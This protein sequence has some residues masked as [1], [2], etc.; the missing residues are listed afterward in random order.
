MKEPGHI[1]PSCIEVLCAFLP[2]KIL[3][4]V[5]FSLVI[6]LLVPT[7]SHLYA[8]SFGCFSIVQDTGRL[9]SLKVALDTLPAKLNSADAVYDTLR[10]KVT[11]PLNKV[12]SIQG[13]LNRSG[14]FINDGRGELPGKLD[15]LRKRSRERL[16]A[17][18][19]RQ[20]ERLQ[21]GVLDDRP[22][23]KAKIE[24]RLTKTKARRLDR[25]RNKLPGDRLGLEELDVPWDQTQLNDP[26]EDIDSTPA[27]DDLGLPAGDVDGALEKVNS[28]QELSKNDDGQIDRVMDQ[29]AKKWL[30]ADQLPPAQQ[31]PFQAQKSQLSGYQGY[32]PHQLQDK[33][34]VKERLKE[35]LTA[36]GK[37]LDFFQDQLQA[38][39]DKVAKH[40]RKYEELSNSHDLET[41]KPMQDKPLRE[42]LIWGGTFQVRPGSPTHIDLSPQVTYRVSPR[43]GIGLG[44]VYRVSVVAKGFDEIL[45][46]ENEIFGLRSFY[47]WQ[48]YK[49]FF[50]HGEYELLNTGT[51]SA[52]QDD[53]WDNEERKWLPNAFLGIKKKYSIS[54]RVIGNL[55]LLYN[56][57]YDPATS[58]YSRRWVVRFGFELAPRD[59]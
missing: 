5:L 9:E 38:S 46:H 16:S 21:A 34:F 41:R 57:S 11:N 19:L 29:E 47:E 3:A 45:S 40:K 6:I 4:S 23:I 27:L 48:A 37:D 17:Y 1:N 15:S 49:G 51:K 24:E 14:D 20:K 43:S 18:E 35:R 39:K 42:R 31:D 33:K 59:K 50:I 53:E 22:E 30:P 56:F 2:K 8:F 28:A 44:A 36:Q 32:S 52:T 25:A 54:R 58:P 26:L 55:Q 13:S 12:D 7:Q 10:D